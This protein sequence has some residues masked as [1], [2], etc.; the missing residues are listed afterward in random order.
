MI[1]ALPIDVRER[2]DRIEREE[3]V[4]PL[5]VCHQAISVFSQ[6]TGPERRALGVTAIGLVMERHYKA[7]GHA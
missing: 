4:P 3:G 1:L 6:L 7:G 2:L 5:E